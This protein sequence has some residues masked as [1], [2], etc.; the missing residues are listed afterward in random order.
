[1]DRLRIAVDGRPLRNPYTGIGIYTREILSRLARH[2][3]LFVYLDDF[4][5]SAL[6]QEPPFPATFRAG[7]K[8]MP[9]PLVVHALF[10]RWA[11][12]DQ[13]DVFFSP[14]HHLPALLADIPTVVTIHDL[15]WR[16]APETMR[17]ANRLLE[18]ALMPVAL[19][20]ADHIIAVSQDTATRL[21]PYRTRNVHV[22][23]EGARR[24][25]KALPYPHPRPFFL[26]VGTKEPRKNLRGIINGFTQACEHGLPPVDL[27]LAGNDGWH[28]PTLDATIATNDRI[29]D[30]GPVT[31][32]VLA[33]LYAGCIAVV[34]AS[35]YEGFGLPLVEAMQRGKPAIA[36][37]TG[38]LA[39]VAADAAVL[40]NPADPTDIAR[41]FLTL[42]TDNEAHSHH[43][44]AAERR[45]SLFSWDRATQDTAEILHAGAR[46]AATVRYLP[47]HVGDTLSP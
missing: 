29:I 15:V 20:R 27:I 9:D 42:G 10:P 33:S 13:A 26:F 36:A 46:P 45:A 6:D 22:I 39:E 43:A 3:D 44:L 24:L 11:R 7:P 23:H 1:M 25:P 18:S 19:K 41:G 34:M 47:A 30:L 14:R 31:E 5:D 8:R 38:S 21:A 17:G 4:R 2:H 32:E 28:E 37:N 40:V 16:V 35:H 12:Q